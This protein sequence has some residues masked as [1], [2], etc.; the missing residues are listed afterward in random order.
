LK[1]VAANYFRCDYFFKGAVKLL[2]YSTSY[3]F[4]TEILNDAAYKVG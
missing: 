2:N 1:K 4:D 3:A